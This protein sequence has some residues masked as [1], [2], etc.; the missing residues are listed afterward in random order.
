[1]RELIIP[2]LALLATLGMASAAPDVLIA[3][4]EQEDYGGWQATGNAFGTGP[5]RGALSGQREVSGFEGKGLVNTYLKKDGAQGTLTSPALKIERR[6]VNFLIGGGTHPGRT[7]LNLMLADGRIAHSTTG[8]NSEKLRA[9]TWDVSEFAGQTVTLQVVD[10]VRGGW[11]HLDVDHLVQSDTPTAK[12]VEKPWDRVPLV[13]FQMPVEITGNYL[14][15]PVDDSKPRSRVS[16]DGPDGKRLRAF[17]IS[18]TQDEPVFWASVDVRPYKGKTLKLEVDL[19]VK[20]DRSLEKIHQSE[21]PVRAK[22]LYEEEFRPRFHYSPQVGW[23]NDPNG[24]VHYKGTWHFFYQYNPYGN[25][26]ANM[27]WGYATSTDLVHWKEQGVA[28]LLPPGFQAYSGGG[29]VDWKNTSGLGKGEH[30][31]ILLYVTEPKRGQLLVYSDDGGKNWKLYSEKP[32]TT[33]KHRDPKVLWYE[34]G[35]HWA[36]TLFSGNYKG[37]F[38]FSTS[39]NGIDW[40]PGVAGTYPG[41]NECPDLAEMAVEGEPGV[42]KWVFFSGA[43]SFGA[44]DC[45]KYAVG[46]FD[47]KV[48]A[49]EQESIV[50][51]SGRDNYSTQLYSDAPDGRHIFVGWITRGFRSA[52]LRGMTANAQFRVPWEL[53]LYR[54]PDGTFRLRRLPVKEIDSLRG[55]KHEWVNAVLDPQSFFRPDLAHRELDLEIAIRPGSTGSFS[56][57]L[58]G[59][60]LRYDCGT[61]TLHGFK[62][63][64][65]LEPI[66]GQLLFRILLDRTSVELFANKGQVVMSGFSVADSSEAPFAIVTGE[67]T[68]LGS[69]VRIY[70]MKSIW[71]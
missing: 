9:A 23:V 65:K 4:F 60:E 43:G 1:M 6:Y 35:Q 28:F 48:F 19:H 58:A 52:Q 29:V 70:E 31:P 55:R 51:D 66:D 34:P 30:P 41:H 11:G 10:T 42:K 24:M 7:C 5:A 67:G 14:N 3:D 56:F 69:L 68:H 61:S 39:K 20:G 59:R 13:D 40:T 36:M 2:I 18:L 47:G 15:L 53:T 25:K 44:G 22:D 45:A 38:N 33:I 37:V 49:A 50:I 64:V 8:P 21:T 57:L 71:K 46:S 12:T 54:A 16:I 17:D 32:V 63:S 62:R 26:W 27:H